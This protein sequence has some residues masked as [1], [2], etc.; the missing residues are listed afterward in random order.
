MVSLRTNSTG[1]SVFIHPLFLQTQSIRSHD[2]FSYFY[3][4]SFSILLGCFF[5]FSFSLIYLWVNQMFV[6]SFYPTATLQ[7][8]TFYN[9][10]TYYLS[11]GPT[12]RRMLGECC[13]ISSLFL[14]HTRVLDEKPT[15]L[16]SS[17]SPLL[18]GCSE[19]LYSSPSGEQVR[20][21]LNF[22]AKSR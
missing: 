15:P 19:G 7:S 22:G 9:T 16:P 10:I 17:P 18:P 20:R 8:V 4:P 21:S 5:S 2:L 6:S 3:R 11:S 13:G 1:T 12:K 14:T